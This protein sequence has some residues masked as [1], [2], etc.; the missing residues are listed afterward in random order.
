MLL[1][2]LRHAVERAA[3]FVLHLVVHIYV[4]LWPRWL[5]AATAAAAAWAARAAAWVPVVGRLAVPPL[6]FI[7]RL[8]TPRSHDGTI[9]FVAASPQQAS[10]LFGLPLATDPD[11][12]G[13]VDALH[14]F[15][16]PCYDGNLN[17]VLGAIKPAHAIEYERDV[18][19]AADGCDVALDWAFPDDNGHLMD[20][21]ASPTAPQSPPMKRPCVGVM[22]VVVGLT[23]DSRSPYIRSFVTAALN[24]GFAVV[25]ANTRGMTDGPG[26]RLTRPGLMSAAYTGDLHALAYGRLTAAAIAARVGRAV[27]AVMA[28]FS[29]GGNLLGKFLSEEGAKLTAGSAVVGGA[30]M[31]APW[32]MHRT[33][34]NMFGWVQHL[35]YQR[36]FSRGLSKY[37]RDNH[38]VLAAG[39]D[40]VD[41]A[42]SMR[43]TSVHEFDRHT[44]IPHF[45]YRSVAEYYTVASCM[46]RLPAVRV[47]LLCLAT[48]DDPI[49]GRT[50]S[51][52][53]WQAL[54]DGNPL[55]VYGELP[56]GGH[57]GSLASPLRQLQQRPNAVEAIA[58]RSLLHLVVHA[59]AQ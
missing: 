6:E 36:V 18:M 41:W 53:Q 35:L 11:A 24:H 10:R 45:R 27:P 5:L 38:A 17:T 2:R 47:P 7:A 37:V 51:R 30:C 14:R 19:V 40:S 22:A 32:E 46:P 26:G 9:R 44:I 28:G 13:R 21:P 20:A 33:N 16:D 1:E 4:H 58:C 48:C 23:S 8:A 3:F 25:V 52:A 59:A 55:V 15:A 49:T 43:S 34:L 54:A 50:P 56:A 39:D 29:L 42:A 31:C 57:L 12:L